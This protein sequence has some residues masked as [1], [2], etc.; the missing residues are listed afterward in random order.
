M[1]MVANGFPNPVLYYDPSNLASYSGSGT[2]INSLAPTNLTGTM[3]NITFTTPYFSYNGTTSQVT[4]ADNALLEPGSGSW[5]MEAWCYI[6]ST[7][8]SQTVL[9]KFNNGGLSSDVSYSIRTSIGNLYSQIGDGTGTY[10]NST[11]YAFT[12][13]SWFHV[14]YVWMTNP[15]TLTTYINGASIG[16]VAHTMSSVL[17][18]ANPLYLGSYNGGEYSQWF[19]GR[20]GIV[21]LYNTALNNAQILQNYN[22]TKGIYGL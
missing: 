3:S 2:T 4:V 19:T 16:S 10:I 22:Q 20:T 13:N 18:S 1:N 8:G 15:K 7:S 5:S 12:T 21:R 11:S 17:N 6:S 14:V 9:G